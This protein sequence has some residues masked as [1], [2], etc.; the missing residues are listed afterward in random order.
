MR[1]PTEPPYTDELRK[2]KPNRKSAEYHSHIPYVSPQITVPTMSK[3]GFGVRTLTSGRHTKLGRNT[4]VVITL[5]PSPGDG[6]SVMSSG[7][8]IPIPW[9]ILNFQANSSTYR[10][11]TIHSEIA[12]CTVKEKANGVLTPQ[13]SETLTKGGEIVL[14]IMKPG[15]QDE[16][17]QGEL[18][19]IN[20]DVTGKQQ[21]TPASANDNFI[22]KNEYEDTRLA[23]CL[24]DED[25][26]RLPI[27]DLGELPKNQIFT[28]NGPLCVQAYVMAGQTV[29][30]PLKSTNYVPSLGPMAV[31][32]IS[33]KSFKLYTK[34]NGT[35][36]LE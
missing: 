27:V 19:W 15:E 12:V 31:G 23:L 17:E 24:T 7:G 28:I 22:I 6:E 26:E 5:V 4:D 21:T 36:I 32:D 2:R 13:L 20:T 3:I 34:P 10:S 33:E 9:K 11:V 18:Q 30:K 8:F 16:D 1:P 35:T 29:G 25:G 14:K